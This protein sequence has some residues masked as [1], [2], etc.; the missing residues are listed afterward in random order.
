MKKLFILALVAVCAF[1]A[2]AKPPNVVIFFIDDMGFADIG[3]F[4]NP[5]VPTP[6]WTGWRR[7]A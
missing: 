4:G 3:A 7:R 6:I 2:Q 1:S 5:V